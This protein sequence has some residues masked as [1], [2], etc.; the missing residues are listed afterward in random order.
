VI[1]DN[2]CRSKLCPSSSG[3]AR[4]LLSVGDGPDSVAVEGFDGPSGGDM[5]GG[6][7]ALEEVPGGI[8]GA[9]SPPSI[10]NATGGRKVEGASTI[11]SVCSDA[12]SSISTF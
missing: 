5:V 9:V 10:G 2:F 3:S 4:F 8:A 1:S 6:D 12:E 7:R 11:T